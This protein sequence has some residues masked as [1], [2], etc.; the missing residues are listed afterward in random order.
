MHD[1]RYEL[2][3]NVQFVIRMQSSQN[4]WTPHCR[5]YCNGNVVEFYCPECAAMFCGDCYDKEHGGNERKSQHGK[6]TERRAICKVHKHTLDY[7]NLTL[8]RPM[9]IICKKETMLTPECE[10][11]VI[12]HMETTVPKLRSLMEKKLESASE[13]IDR[14]NH[15]LARVENV[16]RNTMITSVGYIQCCFARL[17]QLLDERE[18]ELLTNARKYFDDFVEFGEGRMEARNAVRDLKALSA[19]GRC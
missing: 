10:H 6:L 15:E 4:T 1:Q 13:M 2:V 16:A 7:F 8:L 9:C 5:E 14:L 17:R 18:V 11:H 19:E 12:E 3:C